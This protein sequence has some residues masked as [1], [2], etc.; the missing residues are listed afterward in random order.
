[1]SPTVESYR[2]PLSSSLKEWSSLTTGWSCHTLLHVIVFFPLHRTHS[3]FSL[4][5]ACCHT[6]LPISAH[7]CLTSSSFAF[8]SP[9]N[10]CTCNTSEAFC[11]QFFSLSE[12]PDVFLSNSATVA[13]TYHRG[14]NCVYSYC[15]QYHFIV[16]ID[17]WVIP[18]QRLQG[19]STTLSIWNNCQHFPQQLKEPRI[20]MTKDWQWLGRGIRM[21]FLAYCSS[22]DPPVLRPLTLPPTLTLPSDHQDRLCCAI[23]NPAGH[24]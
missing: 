6:V 1:M 11:S 7:V 3:D 22:L 13:S 4:S 10:N 23:T 19:D 20:K 21:H 8:P 18:L 2:P 15:M 16:Q 9:S 14:C 17:Y 24:Q 5:L 12:S